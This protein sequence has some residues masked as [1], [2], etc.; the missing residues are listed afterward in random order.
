MLYTPQPSTCTI[1]RF[2]LTPMVLQK[3]TIG[4]LIHLRAQN[5]HSFLKGKMARVTPRRPQG[6]N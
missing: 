5:P 6:L 1:V 2:A 3:I 4:Y